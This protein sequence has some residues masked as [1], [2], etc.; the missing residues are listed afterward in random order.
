M[1]YGA[2]TDVAAGVEALRSLS[3]PFVVLG[4]T[5]SISTAE[6]LT[7]FDE[8]FAAAWPQAFA[9]IDSGL[10]VS[11]DS[12]FLNELELCRADQERFESFLSDSEY[13]QDQIDNMDF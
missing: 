2:H 8:W 12:E 3:R 4:V 11:F 10:A 5:H 1:P 7:L 6:V 13:R 9:W